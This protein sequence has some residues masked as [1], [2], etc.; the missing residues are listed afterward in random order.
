MVRQPT[1]LRDLQEVTIRTDKHPRTPVVICVVVADDEVF[2]RS[3]R[4]A[5]GHWYR[6]LAAGGPATLKFATRRLAAQALPASD[7]DAVAR[8]PRIPEEISA[9]RP[10]AGDGALRNLA[11]HAAARTVLTGQCR[12][13]GLTAPLVTAGLPA[14][15]PS[16]PRPSRGGARAK[17]SW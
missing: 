12:T 5:K 7:P 8:Q 4:G 3:W 2:V 11:D 16:S 14:S 6:D 9:E 1:L 17:R 10:C 15:L 13:Y